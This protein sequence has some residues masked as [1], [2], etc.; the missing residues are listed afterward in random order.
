[1]KAEDLTYE[2]WSRDTHLTNA[3]GK[4]LY[5]TWREERKKVINL[6]KQNEILKKAVEKIELT[7]KL[8]EQRAVGVIARRALKDIKEVDKVPK[9]D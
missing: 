4:R 9:R 5:Y 3:E 6:T 8:R 7:A 2:E 1:M